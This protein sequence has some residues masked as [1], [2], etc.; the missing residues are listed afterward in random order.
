MQI[1][2]L[3]FKIQNFAEIYISKCKITMLHKN[4]LRAVFTPPANYSNHLSVEIL[5]SS[6]VSNAVAELAEATDY[7]FGVFQSRKKLIPAIWYNCQCPHLPMPLKS[8]SHL[9]L[10]AKF[11]EMNLYRR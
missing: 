2:I 6:F 1:Y 5:Y 7:C 11:T 3:Y 4:N 9:R 8:V 10:R